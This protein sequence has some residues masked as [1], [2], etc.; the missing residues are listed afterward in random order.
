[1]NGRRLPPTPLLR[2]AMA[3]AALALLLA[4]CND[5]PAAP[6]PPRVLDT[7]V[8]VEEK[9]H[10][11]GTADERLLGFLRHRYGDQAALDAPWTSLWLDTEVEAER[12]VTRQVCAR[13]TL[14]T[15]GHL[16]T[17][18]AVCQTVEKAASVEPGRVDLY[19]LRD[20]EAGNALL[21]MTERGPPLLL[22]AQ[23]QQLQYGRHG[24]PGT[25][26]IEALGPQRHAF[27]I[28][29]DQ[30]GRGYA[31]QSRHYLAVQ[32]DRL[33]EVAMLHT[34]TDNLAAHG[35][36]AGTEHCDGGDTLF[37]LDFSLARGN[38]A[39]VGGY[40][41][42]EVRTRGRDC[43]GPAH[44]YHLLVFDPATRRYPVPAELQRDGCADAG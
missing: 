36:D 5:R 32:H 34:H 41:P 27:R 8:Q 14:D 4:G 26:V 3:G 24:A 38:G 28:D 7:T 30:S 20:G 40:W 9:L 18:L 6:K 10:V 37:H 19:V 22:I 21:G 39:A 16:Q 25:V 11:T 13:E 44:A 15:D 23:R 42:L 1:M 12:P 33:R 31:R 17:L 35:C 29:H 2:R 43:D